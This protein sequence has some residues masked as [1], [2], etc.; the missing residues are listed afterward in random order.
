MKKNLTLFALVFLLVLAPAAVAAPAKHGSTK[1]LALISKDDR[2]YG[3]SATLGLDIQPGKNRVFLETFPLTQ[4]TTQV[5]VRFAQQ[6]ACDQLDIDCAHYDFFY[7]I[8]S[9]P[10]IVGG[11]SAG[12]SAAVLTASML[13]G[14]EMKD[15][16]AITGTINSGGIIGSVG[17]IKG[18]IKAAAD[19][20][21]RHVLIPK[22]TRMYAEDTVDVIEIAEDDE[23]NET[24]VT[25]ELNETGRI[26]LVEYGK[27]LSINVTEVATLADALEIFTG[28]RIK[29]PYGDFIID[30]GY[31]STMK[32]VAVDL[33]SR[34]DGIALQLKDLRES[35]GLNASEEE[36]DALN[37]S[38]MSINSFNLS[39]FY[40]AASFCFRSSVVLKQIL[41]R[42]S[43]LSKDDITAAAA[44]ISVEIDEFEKK[45]NS[46]EFDTITGLQTMMAVRERLSEARDALSKSA[47]EKD[48]RK[49][50]EFLAY[51]EERLHSAMSWSRFFD[52]S[53]AAFKLDEEQLKATCQSKINE[54]EER[55]NY[56]RAIVPSVKISSKKGIDDAYSD[57]KNE[58]YVSCL[59]KA[60]KIKSEIDVILG[61]IG[62][63]DEMLPDLLELKQGIVR[64]SLVKAQQ[65]GIFP[66]ISYS[67]Y[68][69]ANSLKE[70][71]RVSALLFSGYALE[72][73]NL[74]IYFQKKSGFFDIVKKA[75][76]RIILVFFLGLAAGMLVMW[77]VRK[78]D[79]CI[80]NVPVSKA[81]K[82]VLRR[83]K[84]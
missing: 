67:Y 23:K 1:L 72:F 68:E 76:R 53:D 64:Q 3:T 31:R 73:A 6:I 11:P 48:S 50:A 41:F 28:H 83:K 24:E 46:T 55:Q 32:D 70:K 18:K 38:A 37:Y 59:Y 8:K 30:S 10:G 4:V 52:C 34:N 57:L 71:D 75:D 54:A 77:P 62:V 17:G 29:E 40:S 7:T 22:G 19:N 65:K 21:I 15:D 27:N 9:L 2:Q 16:M 63:D 25:L 82:N 45:I 35:L 12:A 58:E 5:S 74:N 66:I 51:S 81:R 14:L 39:E 80:K 69:Y 42:L 79:D 43:N 33:C 49:S 84:A 26:D 36:A 56:V 78:K 61:V 20:G 13:L 60:I 44:N 47:G